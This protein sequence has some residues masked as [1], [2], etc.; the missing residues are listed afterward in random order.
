MLIIVDKQG[1]TDADVKTRVGKARTAFQQLRNVM[2]E[3]L[4]IIIVLV[5]NVY[6]CICFIV[7]KSAWK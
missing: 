7:Q 4:E 2:G 3:C 6:N 1:G 5:L